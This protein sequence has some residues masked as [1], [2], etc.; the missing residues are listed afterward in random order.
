MDKEQVIRTF[1]AI[2]ICL[3]IFV[4]WQY[5]LP[6]PEVVSPPQTQQNT[7]DPATVTT[8][9]QV[10]A[11]PVEPT[12]QIV[13]TP[14]LIVSTDSFDVGFDVVTGDIRLVEFTFYNIEDQQ[15][16]VF[17][18]LDSTA[19]NY[20]STSAAITSGYSYDVQRLA[21]G[22]TKVV[23]TASTDQFTVTK[24]YSLKDSSYEIALDISVSNHTGTAVNV[25][26]VAT[27]GP[28]LGKGF[29]DESFVFFGPIIGG[30]GK[31]EKKRA[32]K[33][34]KTLTIDKSEWG[35]YTS[36]YFLFALMGESFERAE[37]NK[38]ENSAVSNMFATMT[39]PAG[40]TE[41]MST[42]IFAGPKHYDNLKTYGNGLQ[43]T[44]D[45]GTFFFLAIP[46]T[47]IMNFSY[48]FV[49]NY[50]I[51]I[52]I[53]TIMVKIIT[54]PLT[55]KSMRSMKGMTK[56][57][58][59]MVKL[60]EKYKGEPAKLNAATMELY[61]QH[62]VNPMGGCLP[63][64]IQLPIFFALYKSLL[65]SIELKGAP[66]ILWITDLSAKDP[67]YVTPIIMGLSMFV[68]QKMTPTAVADPTQQK[69]FM[70]MPLI[71][72]FLFI[73][74]PAGLVLYWLV[75]NLLSIIQQ[76]V[77]NREGRSEAKASV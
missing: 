48:K 17:M 38:K 50:G 28:G 40:G 12:E 10:T 6:K 4:V 54:L 62:K 73:S 41:R 64:I 59:E 43:K 31:V 53:L 9:P 30:H 68:V 15:T 27:V 25:P 77:I 69:I 22:G 47:K 74:F 58:P 5:L 29:N 76:Y 13:S 19:G 72:T 2:G 39:V 1:A 24:E 45:Y 23:F 66:F 71:F 33:V 3:I 56:L 26:V 55:L 7:E 35:G 32:D 20:F 37:I 49:N 46:M 52:I 44:I 75:N 11:V 16:P 8:A 42:A 63:M 70:L 57:Q 14:P 65:V 61:R 18:R 21:E 60:R 67:Y 51:A 36:K 34:K